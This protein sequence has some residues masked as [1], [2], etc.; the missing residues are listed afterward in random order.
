MLFRSDAEGQ[1]VLLNGQRLDQDPAARLASS[2][3]RIALGWR[4]RTCRHPGCG[5]PSTWAL[6]AHHV[7]P[8]GKGGPTVM[9][10][11]ALEPEKISL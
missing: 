9:G 5:R 6:H 8:Y 7:T 10:N 2:A 11:L 4:D 1:P 3:Q